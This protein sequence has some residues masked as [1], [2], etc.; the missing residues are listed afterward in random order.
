MTNTEVSVVTGAFGYTGRYIAQRLLSAGR[1]VKTLTGHPDRSSPLARR[2]EVAPLDF[3]DPD[4]L[5]ASLEGADTL[6]NTYWI[7]FERGHVRFEGAVQNTKVLIKAA[8]N[9][10]VPR[11]IHI[12]ITGAS[13]SSSLPYFRGK[14]LVEAAIANSRLSHAIV[15]PTLIFGAE[16]ILVNNMAWALR[17]SPVFPVFGSGDYRVQPVFVEDVARIAVDAAQNRDN[18]VIDAVG[19]ET[20]TYDQ[21]VRLIAGSVGSRA[22]V[23]HLGPGLAHALTRAMGYVVRDV[24]VTRDEVAGLMAELLVSE[25][26]P[27]GTTPLSEW[28]R[29]NGEQL[30]R[31]YTS[32]LKRHYG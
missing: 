17:R 5:A 7:R 6:F 8:E 28:L 4:G 29:D 2:V 32:E 24:V 16:D 22:R 27:T 21:L 23:V 19:P 31:A 15:R 12:S 25:E 30:G 3:D 14:G 9:A 1:R 18:L 11:L 10:G 13:A 20:L 26:Q